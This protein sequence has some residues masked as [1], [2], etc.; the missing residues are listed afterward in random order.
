MSPRWPPHLIWRLRT[1][2]A[3][4]SAP[5]RLPNNGR[6]QRL[7]FVRALPSRAEKPPRNGKTD[8]FGNRDEQI[9]PVE[10]TR[11]CGRPSNWVTGIGLLAPSVKH[12]MATGISLFSNPQAINHVDDIVAQAARAYDLG[13]RQVWLGQRN[14]HDAIAL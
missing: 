4:P 5:Q 14:D 1:S 9:D 11:R 13:V 10:R 7:Q 12:N 2:R 8:A 3:S 6:R